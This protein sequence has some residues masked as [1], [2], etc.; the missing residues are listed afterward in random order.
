MHPIFLVAA[1]AAGL[2]VV[3][4]LL[5]RQQPKRL[6]FPAVRFLKLRQKSS[7]RRVRL[8]H[9]LLMAL[10]VLLL[11]LFAAALYQP[12]V[13]AVGSL[14]LSGTQPVAVV[15]VLDT[16]PSTGY[17]EGTATR[18]DDARRRAAD[19]LNELPPNSKVAVLATHD[20]A[21]DFQPTVLE[22]RQRIDALKEPSGSAAPLS[23]AL[24]RAYTLLAGVDAD[25]PEGAEPTPKVV[26]VFGDRAL[27][28]WD[29]RDTPGLAAQRDRVPQP[30]PVHLFFDVGTDKPV[31]LAVTDVRMESDRLPAGAEAVLT[32][33]VRADG[34]DVADLEV[35]ATLDDGEGQTALLT[36][37]AG[38]TKPARFAFK[39]LAPGFH[40]VGVKL[41][42]D[43]ALAS[44]N[45]RT[46]TFEVQPRR[47]ILAVA[48]DPKDVTLWRE[49]HNSGTREF[50]CTVAKPGELPP[51][52]GFE[53]VAV[54]AVADPGPM[55]DALTTYVTN[56]GKLLLAPDGPGSV[57][58]R[59]V[60]YNALGK[61]LPCE[62]G[63]IKSL[64]SKTDPARRFGVPWKLSDDADLRHRLFAPA[65]GWDRSVDFFAQPKRVEKCRTLADPPAGGVVVSYDDGDDPK[66]RTPAAVEG[67][68]GKGRV[69]L[70]TTRI[71]DA[72]GDPFGYWNGYWESGHS[73]PVVFPW[74][75]AKYLCEPD[76]PVPTEAGGKRAYNFPTGDGL[77]LAVP[78]AGY[79][80]AGDRRLRLEGPGV[81]AERSRFTV[82]ADVT[83]LTLKHKPS[84]PPADAAGNPLPPPP[85]E[86]WV[87]GTPFGTAGAFA[88]KPDGGES[89]W[90][91]R[92]SLAVPPA[93]SDLTKVPAE[94]VAELF[95][96]DRIVGAE[97][98]APTAELVQAKFTQPLELFYPLVV[99]VLLF[100][101]FEGVV[102]NRFYKLK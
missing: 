91:Y 95:G 78:L 60:A 81:L 52:G 98:K 19:F 54:I 9:V 23:D 12:T 32:A 59:K 55:K 63:D 101:A 68:P 33:F 47:P 97:G 58:A 70:L 87:E 13:S 51:L 75:V 20:P 18:L 53:M 29:A 3:L 82:P 21:G 71:D 88:V 15:L 76:V 67:T 4:H 44:D 100:F 90:Q 79:A 25:A 6:V 11:A 72:A 7:Q 69:L 35:R 16:S 42:R 45:E 39:A 26:A 46:F 86:W 73:W 99:L 5:L 17:R 65:R 10:R 48:D 14:N 43:D 84:P 34:L 31:N 2:P 57:D 49:S 30:A 22:A 1:A 24:R 74:L 80:A 28:S 41:G 36:L 50:L 66:A 61:L 93:E 8:R 94:V 89:P 77:E 37:P 38:S 64:T 96:P 92:F 27:A 56:G 83:T 40:T 62:L 102:A 85:G